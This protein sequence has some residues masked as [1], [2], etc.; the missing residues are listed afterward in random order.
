MG[1]GHGFVKKMC[2]NMQSRRSDVDRLLVAMIAE[3][4]LICAV[5]LG[6]FVQ[7]SIP[8]TYATGGALLMLFAGS[9]ICWKSQAASFAILGLSL[10]AVEIML[11]LRFPIFVFPFAIADVIILIVV[12]GSWQ[13]GEKEL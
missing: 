11:A 3:V 9:L 8:I 7:F 12:S 10:L 1:F 2:A 5:A 4:L 13:T 6:F